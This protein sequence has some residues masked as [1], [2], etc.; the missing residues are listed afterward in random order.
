MKQKEMENMKI[1]SKELAITGMFLKTARL[2]EEWYE[3]LEEPV[4]FIK[5]L[6][7]S[8]V[9]ADIFTFW[10]RLPDIYPKYDYYMELDSIAV[11]KITDYKYWFEKQIDTK[12]RNMIRKAGKKNVEIKISKFSDDFTRGVAEIFN[13]S[14]VRQGKPFWHYGMDAK[15]VKQFFSSAIYRED[16]VG[17]Y[18]NDE[19]IGFIT[20]AYTKN[21]AMLTQIISKIAHRDKAPNNALI[22]KAVEICESKKIPYLCY[23]Y[24][25]KGTLADFK[26]NNAF[27]PMQLPRYYVPLTVKG[28]VAL[29]LKI[30]HGIKGIL[31][32]SI[33]DRLRNL[34]NKWYSSKTN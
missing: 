13:E 28:A 18:L 20:M 19:L 12:T 4:S 33:V 1:N 21:C 2:K 7:K 26:R 10:Q 11:L 9:K 30:H 24:W 17:A 15:G 23:A 31:P 16:I 25:P 29:K 5:D 27:E 22:A 6:K 14:P 32:E 8:K 3:D 34:R